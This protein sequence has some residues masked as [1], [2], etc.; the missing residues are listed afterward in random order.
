ML[1]VGVS[2]SIGRKF[3]GRHGQNPTQALC[4]PT[5]HSDFDVPGSSALSSPSAINLLAVGHSALSGEAIQLFPAIPICI[6]PLIYE[7]FWHYLRLIFS[8]LLHPPNPKIK[9]L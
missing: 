8:P 3:S 5:H 9:Q 6:S 7:V 1:V 4:R 2:F